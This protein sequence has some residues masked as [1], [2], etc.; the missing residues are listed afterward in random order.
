MKA[1]T[2]RIHS[3]GGPEVLQVEQL[4]LPE[5]AQG[6]VTIRLSVLE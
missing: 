1:K 3:A 5:P 4:E 2:V 6:E